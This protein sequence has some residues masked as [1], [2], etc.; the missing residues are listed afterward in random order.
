METIRK[1]T[2]GDLPVMLTLFEQARGIMRQDGNMTQW[3][4]GTPSPECIT[5]DINAGNSYVIEREGKIVATFAFIMGKDP[6]YAKIEGA[7]MN[8]DPYGTIHRLASGP[9]SHGI[10]V[11]CFT[12]CWGIIPNLRIDTHADNH[13]MQHCISK[14]GFKRCGIIHLANGE[15]RIA[16]QKI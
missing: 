15:P 7:W 2:S 9:D 4:D 6:T 14:F 10:A 13:I 1:A 16:Y 3:P 12:F 11:A 8:D 5:S